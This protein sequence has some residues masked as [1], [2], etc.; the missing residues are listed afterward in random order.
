M[1]RFPMTVSVE[2]ATA[3]SRLK[4][5]YGT[6]W[7][8]LHQAANRRQA[9]PHWGQEFRQSAPDIEAHYGQDLL[10]WRRMLA[11]LS[12]DGPS[13]FSTTFS[14]ETGL[15]PKGAPATGIFDSDSVDQ[16][17]AGLAAGVE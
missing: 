2:V 13:T 9:I 5:V 11:E 7:T 12:I 8:Q 3:R 17:L 6:F 10:T 1:Q 16:F 14:Q 4:D 15:E